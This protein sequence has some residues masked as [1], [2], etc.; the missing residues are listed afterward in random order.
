[1]FRLDTDTSFKNRNQA[2]LK[3]EILIYILLPLL[4]IILLFLL[5]PN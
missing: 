1:M 3:R 4:T 2:Y 5:L